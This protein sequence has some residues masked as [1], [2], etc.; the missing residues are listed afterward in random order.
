MLANFIVAIIRKI[1]ESYK[2]NAIIALE[3][4]KSK[5]EVAKKLY[6]SQIILA[7]IIIK[8][9]VTDLIDYYMSEKDFLI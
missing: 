6:E 9:T 1:K 8:K 4:A 5:A 2:K 3:L 7:C